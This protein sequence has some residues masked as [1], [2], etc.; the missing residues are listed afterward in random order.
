LKG[1]YSLSK[2]GK[3][4]QK[5]L[6]SQFPDIASLN[7]EIVDPP[8]SDFSVAI[9]EKLPPLMLGGKKKTVLK[10]SPPTVP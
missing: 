2:R 8:F 10:Q 5:T 3:R 7:L 6:L 9:P 1:P 4:S